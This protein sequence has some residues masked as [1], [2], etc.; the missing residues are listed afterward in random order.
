MPRPLRIHVPEGFYHVTLRGNHRQPIF[1]HGSE[2]VLLNKIVAREIEK[3]GARLHAYCWMT[4]HLHLIVQVDIHPL[5]RV[6]QQIAA[7]YARA[8]QNN[9]ETTGHLFE[10]RYHATLIDTDAYLLEA[11]RYVHQ[12]PVRANLVKTVSEY[13]W[14][15]HAAYLN[16]DKAS[17]VT[18]GFAL[19]LLSPDCE[20]AVVRYRGFID[21]LPSAEMARE[22]AALE[23]GAPLLGRSEFMARH[24]PSPEIAPNLA[25]LLQTTCRHFN[26]TE[27][28]LRSPRRDGRLVAARAWLARTATQDGTV[29]LAAVARALNR[30]EA[31]L[32][33]AIRHRASQGEPEFSLPDTTT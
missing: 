13:S 24:A 6:I 2:R 15:S 16:P 5:G 8:F 21:E 25:A 32:R 22:L 29:T 23:Q 14:S 27:V 1:V 7:Q 20:R 10:N 17:F 11:L 18:T 31:S 33:S 19:R 12:N 3:Y 4:N 28:E 30:D 26:V 9:L